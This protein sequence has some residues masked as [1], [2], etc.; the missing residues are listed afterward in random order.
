MR[1]VPFVLRSLTEQ[2]DTQTVIRSSP[3]ATI[4]SDIHQE[5][6][7]VRNAPPEDMQKPPPL[8]GLLTRP[9]LITIANYAMLSFL[10]MSAMTLVP[11]IWS[12][13]VEFGGLNFSPVSIGLWISLSGCMEGIFQFSV[14]PRVVA[15]F[16]MRRV[17]VSSIAIATVIFAMFP[18]ENLVIRHTTGGPGA[19][20]GLLILLHF[21]S[22]SI[23]G[24]GSGKIMP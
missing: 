23:H 10:E 8:S 21:L 14:F 4:N 12:R 9:V 22:L 7:D 24:M 13:P 2:H 18:L 19:M 11:L 5:S 16:G 15:R 3:T 1:F 6:T 20:I 17:F